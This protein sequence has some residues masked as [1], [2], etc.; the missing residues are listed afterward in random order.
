VVGPDTTLIDSTV[1]A[2]A[3]VLRTHSIG[4]EIGPEA[5]VGPFSFLRPGTRLARKSKVGGFVETKNAELGEGAKVPHLSYVGDATI[6]ANANVGAGTI[7]A[8]YDGLHKHHTTVG[9]AAFIGSDTVLI[10]PAEVGPGAYVAAGSAISGTVP[11]GAL[12][13]TRAP[14]RNVEGWTARKRP[15]SKSDEAAHRAQAEAGE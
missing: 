12:G 3:T 1:A 5:T 14:Q 13:V 4:A 15:G 9:E 11:P 7:F 6:G 8:N 10:A 2:G